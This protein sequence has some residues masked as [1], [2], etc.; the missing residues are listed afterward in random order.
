M[1][2]LTPCYWKIKL[3][4]QKRREVVVVVVVKNVA[5]RKHICLF[6]CSS[7]AATVDVNVDSMHV[8]YESVCVGVI[9]WM[10]RRIR[11]HTPTFF[12]LALHI[13]QVKLALYMMSV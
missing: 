12:S 11:M 5:G 6:A 8:K 2:L 7:H 13:P 4:G 10:S 1:V 9:G 3:N